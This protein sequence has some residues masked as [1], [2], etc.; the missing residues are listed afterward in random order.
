MSHWTTINAV[1][2]IDTN[3]Q[4]KVIK[5]I[6]AHRLSEAPKIT[7]SEG[8]AEMFINQPS[9]Y[10]CSS[11]LDCDNCVFN[12]NNKCISEGTKNCKFQE[13]QTVVILTISG[14]LRDRYKDQTEKEWKAF[15]EYTKEAF[16]VPMFG[17]IK[18]TCKI[19][20]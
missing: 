5:E 10:N 19:E 15:L 18:Y 1:I 3:I 7:G 9:G 14:H 13:F 12:I 20:E 11:D 6:V 16:D 2:E 8:N 17:D 4:S